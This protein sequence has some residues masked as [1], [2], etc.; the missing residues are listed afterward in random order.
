MTIFS[1]PPL[2][3]LTLLPIGLL[4]PVSHM[5]PMSW[6]GAESIPIFL[7]KC[8]SYV[9]LAKIKKKNVQKIEKRTRNSLNILILIVFTDSKMCYRRPCWITF[10][11]FEILRSERGPMGGGALKVSNYFLPK[12]M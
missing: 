6:G 7:Y 10:E 3:Y 9:Q 1:L 12:I 11:I 4:F 5:G 8:K 2:F